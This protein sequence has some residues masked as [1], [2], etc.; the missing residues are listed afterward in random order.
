MCVCKGAVKCMR[1]KFHSNLRHPLRVATLEWKQSAAGS[2]QSATGRGTR[3][4]FQVIRHKAQDIRHKAQVRASLARLMMFAS[5]VMLQ[6]NLQVMFVLR[7]SDVLALPKLWCKRGRSFFTFHFIKT[8]KR[9][10]HEFLFTHNAWKDSGGH[11]DPPLQVF[12]FTGVILS[13]RPK[14]RD[15]INA[16]QQWSKTAEWCLC[17]AQVMFWLRQSCGGVA[18][19][20]IIKIPRLC[21]EWQARRSL[22][23]RILNLEF[24]I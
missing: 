8:S 24:R 19:Q 11:G 16:E 4:W 17:F 9:T 14:R 5:Q 1:W 12:I 23:I 10:L 15:L 6:T 22:A 21:S 13:S 7:A 2:R 3:A 18:T 20:R